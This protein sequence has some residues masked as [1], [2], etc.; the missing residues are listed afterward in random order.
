MYNKDKDYTLKY[1]TKNGEEKTKE[2][3]PDKDTSVPQVINMLKQEDKDFFKL[4]EN[5]ILKK[6]EKSVRTLYDVLDERDFEDIDIADNENGD[7]LVAFCLDPENGDSDSYDRVL[8]KIAKGLEVYEEQED[9]IICKVTDWVEKHKEVLM[10]MFELI[11]EDEDDVMEELVSTD[12]PGLISGY[13]TDTAYN[14]L[15]SKLTE[16]KTI[17]EDYNETIEIFNKPYSTKD[18]DYNFIINEVQ[19]SNWKT[20]H[21]NRIRP[22]MYAIKEDGKTILY[23]SLWQTWRKQIKDITG[24][25]LKELSENANMLIESSGTDLA[26]EAIETFKQNGKIDVDWLNNDIELNIYNTKYL[27]DMAI[28]P[29]RQ[30]HTVAFTGL[31]ETLN[32]R[33][34]SDNLTSQQVKAGF[35]K[36]GLDY[37]EVLKPVVEYIEERRQEDLEE[38]KE[39]KTES[40]ENFNEEEFKNLATEFKNFLIKD[41]ELL[42]KNDISFNVESGYKGSRVDVDINLLYLDNNKLPSS[43]EVR[44]WIINNFSN[45]TENYKLNV[46][47]IK[48][49]DMYKSTV[50]KMSFTD[51]DWFKESKEIKTENVNTNIN[52]FLHFCKDENL[53]DNKKDSLNKYIKEYTKWRTRIKGIDGLEKETK[54]VEEDIQSYLDCIKESKL[55]ESKDLPTTNNEIWVNRNTV[56]YN[57]IGLI[58]DKE[59]KQF[60][61]L[62]A[63]RLPLGKYKKATKRAIREKADEL[64]A[65]GYKE[66]VT[67]SSVSR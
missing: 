22:K 27:Y 52:D 13:L 9:V 10:D 24:K 15:D 32:N 36:L 46:N 51:K 57:T 29:R 34:S 5:K 45:I 44:K 49:H 18:H 61:L 17:N 20:N 2:F 42:F 47:I 63:Q 41:K 33:I 58:I 50:I 16:S 59:N 25:D 67:D 19:F 6:E 7:L 30:A 39:I 38:S 8:T 1:I 40:I 14:E 66:V 3:T 43:I 56:G 12:F 26:V 31:I 21:P 28:N 54:Q 48:S 62:D 55:T 23:T 65:M 35:S 64:E 53:E 11:G 4:I 60:Q 37:K